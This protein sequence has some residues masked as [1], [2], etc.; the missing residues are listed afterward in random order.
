[1]IT[2]ILLLKIYYFFEVFLLLY[3]VFYKLI[4]HNYLLKLNSMEEGELRHDFCCIF[5]F[6]TN[7][8]LISLICNL[9]LLTFQ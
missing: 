6:T 5:G 9:T 4:S 7:T 3:F 8:I 1:M 2:N